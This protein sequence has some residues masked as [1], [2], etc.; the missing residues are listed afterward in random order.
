M[1]LKVLHTANLLL[2]KTFNNRN[3]PAE[4]RQQLVESRFKDLVKLVSLANMYIPAG[5]VNRFVMVYV[6]LFK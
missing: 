1:S 5:F 3:Y 4:V 2:G 6:S